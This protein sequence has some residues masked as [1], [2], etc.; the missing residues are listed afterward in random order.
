MAN[1]I[2]RNTSLE[3]VVDFIEEGQEKNTKYYG[4]LTENAK[5]K[6]TPLTYEAYGKIMRTNNRDLSTAI[7][8]YYQ[9]TFH[10]LCGVNITYNYAAPNENARFITEFYF[11][12][13]AEP[14]PVNKDG[15]PAKLENLVDLTI[16]D[17]P[18]AKNNMYYKRQI[19]ESRAN[20]KKYAINDETKLLLGDIVWGGPGAMK[21]NNG[22]WNNAI[23]EHFLPNYDYVAN[24]NSGKFIIKIA[25]CFD[26][27]R[28]LQKLFGGAM[29][30][31]TVNTK[32]EGTTNYTS[33]SAYEL[34]FIQYSKSEPGIFIMNI[35]QF[36]KR[37]VEEII[38]K[39]NPIRQVYV[40]NVQ[41]F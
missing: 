38:V 19:M 8:T 5:L 22:K 21:P 10:D 6:W 7:K 37:A 33:N 35:E 36:D 3:N 11:S 16:M 30:T 4:D 12:K 40:G 25:G 1:L 34:R 31:M 32:E 9:K 13:N 18:N 29:V 41:Y 39:E 14:C 27:R 28:I 2:E 24:R 26:M 17:N 15:K 23:T 20:G